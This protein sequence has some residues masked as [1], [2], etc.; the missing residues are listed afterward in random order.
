M[1]LQNEKI[2]V[3]INNIACLMWNHK[4]RTSFIREDPFINYVTTGYLI[5]LFRITRFK[6]SQMW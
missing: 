1:Y 2:K 3:I 5:A 6:I 4:E